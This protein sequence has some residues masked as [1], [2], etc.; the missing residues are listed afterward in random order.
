MNRNKLRKITRKFN[1]YRAPE[2]CAKT[3]KN[4]EEKLI[5]LFTGTSI[6]SCCFD[7]HFED[8]R[9]M[10]K[11]EGNYKIEEIIGGGNFFV[12]VYRKLPDGVCNPL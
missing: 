3:L 9:I 12:V 8:Y 1:R 7:E 2:C 5:I 11:E 4:D 6:S 10:L